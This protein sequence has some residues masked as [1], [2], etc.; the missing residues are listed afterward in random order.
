M[1][2][3]LALA[4]LCTAFAIL[5]ISIRSLLKQRVGLPDGD[6]VYDD[7]GSWH[8][9]PE[10]LFHKRLAL[11]GKPDYVIRTDN[12]QLIPVEYKSA[13]APKRPY[14]SHV[15]QLAAYCALVESHFGSRPS[16]GIIRYADK[17]FH[18]DY[19]T[20]LEADLH[21][22]L[23]EMRLDLASDDV[24]RSHEEWHRCQGCGFKDECVD[25]LVE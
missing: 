25:S 12:G 17:S 19:T 5:A 13:Q 15:M 1:T 9:V 11:A 21:A 6:L 20:G 7:A 23:D 2:Q 3:L 16:Y 22:I 8:K 24:P 14:E 18:I 10:P 4:L